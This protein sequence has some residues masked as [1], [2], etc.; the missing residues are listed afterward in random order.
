[1]TQIMFETFNMPV[2]Y[3][4]IQAVLSLYASVAQ[5]LYIPRGSFHSS[6][7]ENSQPPLALMSTESSQPCISLKP[8]IT[9]SC[10]SK[11]RLD[12][13]RRSVERGQDS[14]KAVEPAPMSA[15]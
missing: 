7:W 1:M 8:P 10:P 9:T 14:E 3:V 13:Y 5:K 15:L 12:G 4:A 11:T 2:M 6:F